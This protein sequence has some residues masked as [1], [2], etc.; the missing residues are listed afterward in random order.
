MIQ[1]KYP[2]K[3]TMRTFDYL[4]SDF[5]GVIVNTEIPAAEAEIATLQEFGHDANFAILKQLAVISLDLFVRHFEA[6]PRRSQQLKETL[7]RRYEEIFQK[8]EVLPGFLT[9]VATFEGKWNIVTNQTRATLVRRLGA[10][11]LPETWAQLAISRDDVPRVKPA[12]DSYTLAIRQ[13]GVHP[14]TI[15]AVEDS[16]HGIRAAIDAG[17]FT[18]GLPTGIFG[19]ADLAAA[20][21]TVISSW[22]DVLEY[23]NVPK[24]HLS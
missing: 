10:S 17:L 5:D 3:L 19:P 16:P 8:I 13:S 22:Y 12:P 6:D 4:L 7:S 21:A 20:G 1:S 14:S 24:K 23:L 2:R 15:V 18:L 9:T 11:Q